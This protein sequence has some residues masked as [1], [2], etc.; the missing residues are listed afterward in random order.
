[1]RCKAHDCSKGAGWASSTQG[2]GGG[3]MFGRGTGGGECIASTGAEVQISK[4]MRT[5]T[6]LLFRRHDG[7]VWHT[8][9]GTAWGATGT[10]RRKT[11]A[12][13]L[14]ATQHKGER[15]MQRQGI[16]FAARMAFSVFMK[17]GTQQKRGEGG[18]AGQGRGAAASQKPRRYRR[19]RKRGAKT[20]V[21]RGGA[22]EGR[23][24][25]WGRHNFGRAPQAACPAAV[26]D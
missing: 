22:G 4:F 20:R 16:G 6:S 23:G 24:Q 1:M 8:G 26:P 18:G 19:R 9:M 2:C 21:G 7:K 10:E 5:H 17:S 14:G 15:H 12:R 13:A 11:Q 3:G 25:N